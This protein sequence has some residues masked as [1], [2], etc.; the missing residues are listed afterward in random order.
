MIELPDKSKLPNG[1]IYPEP[2]LKVVS[3]NLIR[4]D[5]WIIM[6]KEQIIIRLEGLTN[7]YPNRELIPF[8]KRFDND[9]VACFELGKGDV[10]QIIHDFSSSGYEQRKEYKSFWDWFRGSIDEMIDFD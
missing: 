6:D 5:P 2:Y 4:L 1:F 7:R 10:V 8:A 9:D 3:L